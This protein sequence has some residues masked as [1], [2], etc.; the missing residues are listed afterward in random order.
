MT[1]LAPSTGCWTAADNTRL[2]QSSPLDD[3]ERNKLIKDG[4]PYSGIFKIDFIRNCSLLGIVPHPQVIGE[5]R[6]RTVNDVAREEDEKLASENSDSTQNGTPTMPAVLIHSTPAVSSVTGIDTKR[7]QTTAKSGKA[8]T[9]EKLT[10]AQ[11]AAAELE[12][13]MSTLTLEEQKPL[14]E[15]AVRGWQLDVGTAAALQ[16]TLVPSKSLTTLRFWNASLSTRAI[17][18]IADGLKGSAVTKLYLDYNPLS[19]TAGQEPS[20]VYSM[21]MAPNSPLQVL[22]LRGNRI[23]DSIASDIARTASAS[24]NLVVL[25]LFDNEIGDEG[26]IAIAKMISVNS[27][28]Q[29]LN[30]GHN[31]IEDDG[32]IALAQAFQSVNILDKEE[33]KTLKKSGHTITVFKNRTMR[34][35]NQLIKQLNLSQNYIGQA[36]LQAW[37]DMAY[38]QMKYTPSKGMINVDGEDRHA[39]SIIPSHLQTVLAEN[40][41]TL[42]DLHAFPK[43]PLLSTRK[44][45]RRTPS[46]SA[47]DPSSS[48]QSTNRSATGSVPPS[49]PSSA[50]PN[51]PA[52]NGATAAA[53]LQKKVQEEEDFRYPGQI[54]NL[55]FVQLSKQSCQISELLWWQ[56]KSIPFFKWTTS[57]T[58]YWSEA[59][60]LDVRS[61]DM[62]KAREVERLRQ[63]AQSETER[64]AEEAAKAAAALQ[65]AEAKAAQLAAQAAAQE[66]KKGSAKK[67]RKSKVEP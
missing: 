36:G 21:L 40:D 1:T 43:S 6:M 47:S 9:A 55:A 63:A 60:T 61:L 11:R 8:P 35:A 65:A 59:G 5:K 53:A 51:S 45:P 66:K 3:K 31:L 62:A 48:L 52:S 14:T 56:L 46:A 15:L 22:S 2:Y 17:T 49:K 4:G 58:E 34:E 30:L 38:D 42:E 41:D 37:V 50:S 18:L 20:L 10:P 67:E 19:V 25:D 13:M 12:K 39:S 33:A 7:K 44:T 54:N 26:A 32:A 28:L 16:L 29:S 57:P 27:T 64:A 24:K 23:D